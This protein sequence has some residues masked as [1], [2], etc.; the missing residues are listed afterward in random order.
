MI[1]PTIGSPKVLY[2]K[3]LTE[4]FKFIYKYKRFSS[5]SVKKKGSH[6][7]LERLE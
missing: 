6:T 2:M 5:K 1:D 7:G 3:R 4:P